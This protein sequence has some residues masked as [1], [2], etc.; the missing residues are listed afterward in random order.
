[1]CIFGYL[2]IINEDEYESHIYF[3]SFKGQFNFLATTSAL[4]TIALVFVYIGPHFFATF[5]SD[6]RLTLSSIGQVISFFFWNGDGFVN[7]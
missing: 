1:M 7:S 4:S 2:K 3:P 5:Y 6:Y